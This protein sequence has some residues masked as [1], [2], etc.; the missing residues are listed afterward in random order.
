MRLRLPYHRQKFDYDCGAAAMK[1]ALAVRGHR[2]P[3]SKLIRQLRTTEKAG[4]TRRNM[5]R[6]A[7]FYGLRAEAHCDS[8]LAEIG[9]L[10]GRG[11]TVIVEY[12]LPGFEGAHYAVFAGF[13]PGRILL[14]DPT[15]G[16]YYSL[17]KR[18]FLKRWY[19][20]HLTAHKRWRLA[21]GPDVRA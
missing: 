21:I 4:T 17:G 2:V 18:E 5:A 1:M 14:H 6:V 7:R 11:A 9:R 12:I 8:S 20:R 10:T 16:P 19:G 15:H 13:S 3:L